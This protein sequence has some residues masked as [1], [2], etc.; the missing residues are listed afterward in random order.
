MEELEEKRS[1]VVRVRAWS[2]TG[3]VVVG[4]CDWVIACRWR[5]RSA[6]IEREAFMT[7]T[8][9]KCGQRNAMVVELM[10]PLTFVARTITYQYPI[11]VLLFYT[12]F[13][14]NGVFRVRVAR[15]CLADLLWS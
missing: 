5:G 2:W 4:R 9:L 13:P 14:P 8:Y 10:S 11:N 12:H 1:G 3:R 15:I 7:S 6:C